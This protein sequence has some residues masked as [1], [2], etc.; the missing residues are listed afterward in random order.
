ME[1]R[2]KGTVSTSQKVA[3]KKIR[4]VV[5][6]VSKTIGTY[7]KFGSFEDMIRVRAKGQNYA[8]K[9]AHPKGGREAARARIAGIPGWIRTEDDPAI[10]WP[11]TTNGPP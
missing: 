3:G 1:P 4:N 9:V 8:Q 5:P 2:F 11:W 6:G 7:V 10:R